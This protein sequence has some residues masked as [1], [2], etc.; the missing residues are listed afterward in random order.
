M[1]RWF[2][3]KINKR[4]SEKLRLHYDVERSIADK[5]K[6]ANKEERK[7]IYHSM[8]DELFEKVKDHPRLKKRETNI[9]KD[10]SVTYNL[11]F[12][13]KH[14]ENVESFIEFAPG[15]GK[16]SIKIAENIKKV[17]AVDIS[18]QISSKDKI[19]ENMELVIYDGYKLDLPS[20]SFDLIFSNQLIEHFHPEETKLHFQ[21]VYNLLKTGGTYVFKTPHRFSGPWDISM[22][23]SDIAQGF[24]LKE[25][26]YTE[27]IELIKTIG[28]KNIKT[29][30]YIKFI[31]FKLPVFY[32]QS[33]EKLFSFFP[34]KLRPII[35]FLFLPH[36]AIAAKK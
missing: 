22:Y 17:F 10:K 20:N 8:Y 4:D 26:T 18:N 30:Y 28:F 11:S 15:D 34:K 12:L 33:L 1:I 19:P 25:W 16:L 13:K 35:S 2:L 24:H 32:F 29:Y 27:L 9:N 5:L 31:F 23:F 14:L 7:L 3:R 21:L 36:I 6:K